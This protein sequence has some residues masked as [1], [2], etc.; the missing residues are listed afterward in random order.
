MKFIVDHKR[1]F[2]GAFVV[3]VLG[4]LVWTIGP[5]IGIGETRPLAGGV[6]RAITIATFALIWLAALL[7]LAWRERRRNKAML[8]AL[9]ADSEDSKLSKHESEELAGRFRQA[10]T[11][12]SG[13]KL[14][15]GSG[16]QLLY[17]LPW[18]MFIGAPGSGKTTA[19]VN[20]GLKFPLAAA[21]A[22]ASE[23][24]GIGGTR[25][26]DWW[27]TEEAV[28]IDTAGRYVTQDSNAQVDQ[29][30]WQTFLRL[31]R[32]YRPRQPINGIIVTLS[33]SDLLSANDAGR[34]RQANQVRTRVEELQHELGLQ[35]PVYVMV[36]KCDLVSG[37]SEFFSAFDAEQRN[38][39]WGSTFAFDL[40]TRQPAPVRPGFDK[41]FPALVERLNHLLIHR[42]A[43]ERDVD[44]RAAM[45][46]FPQQFASL[47]PLIGSWLDSAFGDSRYAQPV[48]VR[49]VY[50]TSGTQFGSP[51][52]R[53]MA[54]IAQSLDLRGGTKRAAGL[55]SAGKSFFI[56]GLLS[57]VIFGEAGLAGHSDARETRMRRMAWGMAAGTVL[58][59]TVLI[60]LWTW[61]FF[62]NRQGLA[63]ASQAAQA[64]SKQLSMLGAP[65]AGDLPLVI[66]AL[67]SMLKV[68]AAVHDP[69]DAPPA[70]MRFGLYQ[71]DA[72]AER[73][74]E[75]YRLAL[76]QG[77]M[78][79]VAVQLEAMMAAPQATPEQVYAALK[80]YLMMY[81]AKR[82]DRA[83]FLGTVTDLW[84]SGYDPV[85]AGR[86][87]THLE[88]LSQAGDLLVARFHPFNEEILARARGR[89]AS[90]SLVDRAFAMLRLS[91]APGDGIRLSEVLGPAGVGVL[92][93][94]SAPIT[95]PIP[96]AFTANGY[97][98]T[99]KASI[100]KIARALAEEEAWVVGSQASGVGRTDTAQITAEVQRRYFEEYRNVWR[101][102]LADLHLRKI[103]SLRTAQTMAQVLSQSDS[104]LRRLVA[105]VAEQ[106]RVSPV[107]PG[108]AA[109]KAAEDAAQAKLKEAA[110]SATSGL[111]GS[112][113]SSVVAAALPSDPT[114]QLERQLEDHF[115]DMRR[116]AGDDKA[117]E[118]DAA[119]GVISEIAIEL[120]GIQQ[121][122]SS[123]QAIREMPAGLVKASAQAER[124]PMPVS[125]VIKDLVAVASGE[126]SG[127]MKK[128]MQAGVGGA[129]SMCRRSIPGRYPFDRNAAL[130]VGAQDFVG[131]FKSGGDLDAFFNSNLANVVDRS[132]ASWRLKASGEGAPPVSAATLRQFQNAEAIRIAFLGG[133][134]SAQVVAD[135]T[136]LSADGEVTLD[137]DGTAHKLKPGGS[138]R[139]NWPARPGAKLSIG[140]GPAVQVE[141][142]WALFR[143]VD[144]A[145][146]DPSSAGDRLKLTFSAPG[147]SKAVVEV[148]T[149]SAAFNPFR[150]RELQTFAC[151]QE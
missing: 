2:V 45:Y 108:G 56:Q 138:T 66:D 68:P 127:G 13:K 30:A 144:K 20:S 69:V 76:Q 103:D 99:I 147:G 140:A 49:G 5:L 106:T 118:I 64:S 31:L 35:F 134:S 29:S 133:G 50:F 19:L 9:S 91:G 43:E 33:I 92:E 72:V 145:Q 130:D 94:R 71:G 11:T 107:G 42:L 148:R 105:V 90:S 39:V 37:F 77:L 34:A 131:V 112:Q 102:A 22:Q 126:A 79:R 150:L 80:T 111:F 32:K 137:Y 83:W 85:L 74:A 21:G 122:L 41:E 26:C 82:L 97:R 96:A 73:V 88:A 23:V 12:L 40:A 70:S 1:W 27:F 3:L 58:L 141:G 119:L 128:E 142:A 129:A 139:L 75:R 10:M 93:R 14:G 89:V 132:G 36:T 109:T 113:A 6:A 143:L 48:I 25:N 78:P 120:V 116:L 65:A 61:S 98:D 15:R 4:V 87:R 28:L 62:G 52:D 151:P 115:A 8:D 114:R 146:I 84:R 53:V 54:G 16:A 63:G 123:G 121:R 17:R 18:Y 101:S 38:R 57:N 117:G 110:T 136:L 24:S 60:G 149:G 135:F 44:R 7:I 67:D 124:F 95:E 100:D 81:D 104:P 55:A 59:G 86:G 125:S 46:A 47:G 51:I